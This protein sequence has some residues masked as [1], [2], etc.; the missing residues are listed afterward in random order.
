MEWNFAL[1]PTRWWERV[2]VWK[3]LQ[4]HPMWISSRRRRSLLFDDAI[5]L[6]LSVPDARW[7]DIFC[8]LQWCRRWTHIYYRTTWNLT[9]P[10][11][12][13]LSSYSCCHCNLCYREMIDYRS[14][15]STFC[16]CVCCC[17]TVLYLAAATIV[18]PSS[19]LLSLSVIRVIP[20]KLARCCI[21]SVV[22]GVSWLLPLLLLSN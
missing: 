21:S 15:S 16:A 13:R 18:V 6:S 11:W 12:W 8:L 20:L 9:V 14:Q 7:S 5:F 17:Y 2:K 22:V 19:S 4:P 1:I 3:I 10:C